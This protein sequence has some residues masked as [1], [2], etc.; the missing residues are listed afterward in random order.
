MQDRY[1]SMAQ[2]PAQEHRPRFLEA[3][4]P[5]TFMLLPDIESASVPDPIVSITQELI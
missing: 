3:R 5:I 1:Q 2:R 4:I